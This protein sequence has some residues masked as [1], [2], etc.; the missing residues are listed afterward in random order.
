MAYRTRYAFN[1]DTPEG[2]EVEIIIAED[3]YTGD[4]L[5]RPVGG[6]PTLRM[7]NGGEILGTSLEIPAECQVADEF[8]DLYTSDPTRFKVSLYI[9][10]VTV[11]QGFITPELYSAPWVDPPHDV[12][13][14]ATDGLG[15]LKRSTFTAAGVLSLESHLSRLLAMTGLSLP[16]SYVNLMESDWVQSQYFW[17]D[18]RLS[19]DHMAGESC[20]DVLQALLRSFHATLRQA[21]GKWV[22]IRETDCPG[23]KTGTNVL[24]ISGNAYPIVPFGSARSFVNWPVGS[25]SSEI[26]PARNGL[27]VVSDSASGGGLLADSDMATDSWSGTATHNAG[28]KRYE[29][30]VGEY[31]EEDADLPDITVT[32]SG[33]VV[34]V[35][36]PPDLRLKVTARQPDANNKRNIKIQVSAFGHTLPS[37]TATRYLGDGDGY[38]WSNNPIYITKELPASTGAYGDD[39]TSFE[40]IVPFARLDLLY[41]EYPV[42]LTVRIE[43]DDATVQVYGCSLESVPPYA[44]VETNLVISNSARGAAPDQDCAFADTFGYYIGG[45]W[46]GNCLYG[47]HSGLHPVETLS[48]P[49]VQAARSGIFLAEDYGLSVAVPRLRLK[50]VIHLDYGTSVPL[51][52]SNGGLDYIT[53]EWSYD[54]YEDEIDISMISLPAVEMTVESVEQSRYYQPSGSSSGSGG[55]GGGGGG[56]GATTLGGLTDVDLSTTPPTSGQT[57]VYN[58]ST[59]LWVPGN[60]AGGSRNVFYGTCPTAAGT[61]VKVVTA[62]G[63]AAANLAEGTVLYVLFTNSNT[64]SPCSLDINGTG[65]KTVTHGQSVSYMWGNNSLAAFVFENNGWRLYGNLAY[66]NRYGAVMLVNTIANLATTFKTYTSR[67]SITPKLAYDL[68]IKTLSAPRVKIHRGYDARQQADE[69]IVTSHPMNDYDNGMTGCFV[70][71]MYSKRRRRRV[72]AKGASPL[73]AKIKEGWGEARGALATTPAVTWTASMATLDWLRGQII[74]RYVNEESGGAISTLAAFKTANTPIFGDHTDPTAKRAGYKNNRL[75]GVAWRINN[76]EYVA[77]QGERET[78]HVDANGNPRYFYSE[79]APFRVWINQDSEDNY[80]AMGFQVAPYKDGRR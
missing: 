71:M 65:Q 76:P 57:I 60:A 63:F 32:S 12:A 28:K 20:Y 17:A 43:A 26:Q 2:R 34:T 11:W 16:L 54:I 51:F 24:D 37:V 3:G 69:Y 23:S 8:A 22:V 45:E 59:G 55:S 40:I 6:H 68:Y 78:T 1:F 72:T 21:R 41:G 79:V 64:V 9:N 67:Y 5:I 42:T 70:L 38:P 39:V 75:F 48:S 56:G 80:N 30:A 35:S 58:G 46:N 25:L 14:T 47:Y 18:T 66:T 74:Q 61:A 19:L 15:E 13:I 50:G 7:D 27:K 73:K 62:S 29:I 77:P 31:I 10:S 53:E 36:T 4:A 33:G 44:G 49:S 52:L